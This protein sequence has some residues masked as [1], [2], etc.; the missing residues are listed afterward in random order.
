MG[1]YLQN[2]STRTIFFKP[3][4]LNILEAYGQVLYLLD[5]DY[6]QEE[7]AHVQIMNL[8]EFQSFFDGLC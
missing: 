3:I 1:L 4:K 5:C 6:I 2:S 8:F 7:A